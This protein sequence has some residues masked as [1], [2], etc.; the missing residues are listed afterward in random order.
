MIIAVER[1]LEDLKEQLESRGFECF[2]I[3]EGRVADAVIYKDRDSHPYFSVDNPALESRFN[4]AN[5]TLP[6]V[7]LINAEN[8][9]LDDIIK[10]LITRT[11]S[12]L[13]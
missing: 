8:K 9:S 6:G 11:Y 4:P 13:F 12:P 10:I 3:G 5:S 2:Y 7:L 1:G